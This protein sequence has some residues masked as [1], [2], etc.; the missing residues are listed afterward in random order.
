M[1]KSLKFS[2][3]IKQFKYFK[4]KGKVDSYVILRVKKKKLIQFYGKG[5]PCNF[6]QTILNVSLVFHLLAFQTFYT[7]LTQLIPM[8]ISTSGVY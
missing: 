3:Q 4:K 1:R 5:N 8:G 2:I 6:T 7:H